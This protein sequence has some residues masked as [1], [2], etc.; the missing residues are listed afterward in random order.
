MDTVLVNGDYLKDA[1]GRPVQIE[2]IHEILQRA[3]IRMSVRKGSFEYDASLGSELYK[4][5]T[6]YIDKKSLNEK[7]VSYAREAL[8]P[9]KGIRILGVEAQRTGGGENLNLL[10]KLTVDNKV[11]E[12]EVVV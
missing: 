1:K 10:F 8:E 11:S 12:M 6:S 9:I 7:I 4:L 3:L 2:G 5:K